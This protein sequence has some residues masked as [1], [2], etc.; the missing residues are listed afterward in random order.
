MEM[1]HELSPDK[2]TETNNLVRVAAAEE[3]ELIINRMKAL[4]KR[5]Q[6]EQSTE[7]DVS[8]QTHKEHIQ[9]KVPITAG[10]LANEHRQ[11]YI[12]GDDY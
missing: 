9:P 3:Q 6:V 1:N 12:L 8:P 11:R 7:Q 2:F 4:E 5:R 10:S